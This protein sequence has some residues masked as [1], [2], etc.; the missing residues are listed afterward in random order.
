MCRRCRRSDVT[1]VG[2]LCMTGG[3]WGRQYGECVC[4]FWEFFFCFRFAMLGALR[5]HNKWRELNFEDIWVT[6]WVL[7]TGRHSF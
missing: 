6:E 3:T 7:C 1:I 4:E 2:I 5:A